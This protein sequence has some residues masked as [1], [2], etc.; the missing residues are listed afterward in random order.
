M[1]AAKDKKGDREDDRQKHPS[2]NQ[3]PRKEHRDVPP[4]PL[5]SRN[6]TNSSSSSSSGRW[7]GGGHGVGAIKSSAYSWA[8][9]EDRGERKTCS[10]RPSGGARSPSLW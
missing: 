9:Q 7:P 4:P 8:T 5:P 2:A 10:S 6:N 1:H 3:P